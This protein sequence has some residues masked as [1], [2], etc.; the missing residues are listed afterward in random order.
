MEPKSQITSPTARSMVAAGSLV[1]VEGFAWAGESAVAGVDLSD[2]DGASWRP[3]TLLDA[4]LPRGWVRWR[5][6]WCPGRAGQVELLAR[7]RDAR[8]RT[9]PLTRDLDRGSYIV[10]EVVPYPVTVE[11][12]S[13]AGR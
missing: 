7:C 9:Q 1:D 12:R 10:N 2:D 5:A 4:A 8:G 6:P 13:A 11:D 3:A